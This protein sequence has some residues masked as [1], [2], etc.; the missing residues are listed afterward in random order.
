M[1]FPRNNFSVIEKENIG[2]YNNFRALK[3]GS[4]RTFGKEL[5]N[6]G[7]ALQEIDAK[8]VDGLKPQQTE[9]L[10]INNCAPVNPQVVEPFQTEIMTYLK[11]RESLYF[12]DKDYMEKQTDINYRMRSILIDWLIDVNLKFKLLPQSLFMTVNLLD[13]YLSLRKVARHELQLV[14]VA[15]LMIV[16]KFEEIYPPVLKDY[17]AVCDNAYKKEDILRMEESIIT[18]LEFNLTQ[19]SSYYYLQLIHQ[20][21]KL[22]PRQLVFA[23]YIL[24]TALLDI[25]ALKFGNLAIVAG[26]VCL[27]NKIFKK[28]SW[29]IEH[30]A[31]CRVNEA[32]AKECAKELYA[33]MQSVDTTTLTSIK[34]KFSS[35]DYFEVSR[36]KIEKVSNRQ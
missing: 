35:K 21:L 30:T 25:S 27:V 29:N 33:I 4:K 10:A 19:P 9:E 13:R 15:C 16:G 32:E 11:S 5:L 2:S 8:A 18:A 34:R 22:D 1:Q 26:A 28:P 3:Q 7:R 23:Q 14:G 6:Q 17:I 24:E 12:I 20:K 36:Y 31:V